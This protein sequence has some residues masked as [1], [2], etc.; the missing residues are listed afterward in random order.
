[1]SLTYEPELIPTWGRLETLQ[2]VRKGMGGEEVERTPLE[3]EESPLP[4]PKALFLV[5]DSPL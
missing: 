3:I 4:P 2:E 5:S 1:M